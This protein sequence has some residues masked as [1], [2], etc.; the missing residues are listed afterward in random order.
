MPIGSGHRQRHGGGLVGVPLSTHRRCVFLPLS[1]PLPGQRVPRSDVLSPPLQTCG[2]APRT[3]APTTAPAPP[4]RR[5]T[6]SA[7]VPLAS[8][9]RTARR[10]TGPARSTGKC[11]FPLP[12]PRAMPSPLL[13]PRAP[14]RLRPGDRAPDKRPASLQPRG[15][16]PAIRGSVIFIIS[17]RDPEGHFLFPCPPRV[18]EAPCEWQ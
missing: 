16:P 8:R 4:C 1:P 18:P 10:K 7:P 6:T 2:L 14:V 17:S 3:P 5:A 9:G 15:G 12:G 11:P 13:T